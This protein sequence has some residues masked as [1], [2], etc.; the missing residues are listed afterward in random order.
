MEK[1]TSKMRLSGPIL[2]YAKRRI[3]AERRYSGTLIN[4]EGPDGVGKTTLVQ[5]LAQRFKATALSTP[6]NDATKLAR[7]QIDKVAFEQPLER[8]RFFSQSNIIDSTEIEK[9]LKEGETIFLD[10]FE[11]STIV[12]NFA[13]GADL[14]S[15]E[16]V[17]EDIRSEVKI[18]VPN[19]TILLTATKE[20]RLR[21]LHQR[22][23]NR[24]KAPDHNMDFDT[25][26]QS[27]ITE[28][29]S[30]LVQ[31]GLLEIDTTA[32]TVEEVVER[33]V[34]R[35]RKSGFNLHPR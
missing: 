31:Y 29:Y 10:R 8:F 28:I 20:E 25:V 33:T 30:Q 21:R 19:A 18:V 15:A 17:I 6:I 16:E 12:G 7:S 34:D 1:L 32:I 5:A 35:L 4:I 23:R 11:L 9:K 26:L 2:E 14:N 22:L 27:N 13:L 3:Q 24:E